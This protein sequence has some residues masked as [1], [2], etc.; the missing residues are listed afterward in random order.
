MLIPVLCIF[1]LGEPFGEL[2]V[3]AEASEIGG[4]ER[5]NRSRRDPEI[6]DPLRAVAD[7]IVA[8]QH[9]DLVARHRRRKKRNRADAFP[10]KA[11]HWR[12]REG[13]RDEHSAMTGLRKRELEKLAE[14]VNARPA[15]FIHRALGVR[16]FHGGA[17]R[18]G[19][20]VDIDR[21]KL[22]GAAAEQQRQRRKGRR[23][24]HQRRE[25]VEELILG[26]EHDRRTND[27]RARNRLAP[28]A[29]RFALGARIVAVAGLI[30]A[31]RRDM[32]EGFDAGFRGGLGDRRASLRLHAGEALR[33]FL[34]QDADKI[35]HGVG[36]FDRAGDRWTMTDIRLEQL[37]LPDG[38]HRSQELRV[39]RTADG[40]AHA[41]AAT[42]EFAHD[43]AADKTGP[44]E[45]DRQLACHAR[46]ISSETGPNAYP[47]SPAETTRDAAA[48]RP[49]GVLVEVLQR[50]L[51]RGQRLFRPRR[52]AGEEGGQLG[53]ED[54]RFRLSRPVDRR[55]EA[56]IEYLH[57]REFHGPCSL[58]RQQSGKRRDRRLARRAAPAPGKM[59]VRPDQYRLPRLR[60]EARRDLLSGIGQRKG[61]CD[62]TL[63]IDDDRVEVVVEGGKAGDRSLY[64]FWR[65][66]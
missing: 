21:L 11:D 51:D 3:F 60:A 43:I 12:Q 52:F 61:A 10:E 4:S 28:R 50:R 5:L 26:T 7:D 41:P 65:S 55:G 31:D 42:G 22:R 27:D 63:R 44:A 57:V 14:G 23:Y 40:G 29:F 48:R 19:D 2:A 56:L 1:A 13:N 53:E 32:N 45:Y 47:N 30:G 62:L 24:R 25:F 20:I 9:L 37:N 64:S 18:V 36:A 38:S 46:L 35:D 39:V 16:L 6:G 8:F 15:Q 34:G 49:P 33:A 58:N 59:M 54:R 66:E 17:D